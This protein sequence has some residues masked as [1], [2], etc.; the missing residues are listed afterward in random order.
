MGVSISVKPFIKL[1]PDNA[2]AFRE[3]PF[4]SNCEW[5]VAVIILVEL[6]EYSTNI[7]FLLDQQFQFRR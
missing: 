5:L 4:L 3:D 6:I 7:K 2:V 1:K